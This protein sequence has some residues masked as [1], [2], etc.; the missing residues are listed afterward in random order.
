MQNRKIRK[1]KRIGALVRPS[2]GGG[3][4][5]TED[6]ARGAVVAAVRR[7]AGSDAGGGL[8]GN[9]S[10][11]WHR[12]GPR[13][14]GMLI[15]PAATPPERIGGDDIVWMSLTADPAPGTRP[16]SEWR[17]HRDLY[18]ARPGDGAVVHTHSPYATAL[19]CLPQIQ[20]D[21]LP[22]SH[23][24]IA[25]A[26]GVSL[27]CA[28]YLPYGTQDLSDATIAAIDGRLACL[29]AHHGVVATG[30]T[31]DG[32]LE[33]AFEV[34]RLARIHAIALSA[35]TPAILSPAQLEGLVTRFAAEGRTAARPPGE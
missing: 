7:M 17:M 33:L 6:D 34:E 21:G 29:L 24:M 25:V 32:G 11:R 10:L 5:A 30:A 27:R 31:L 16:S 14:A 18:C 23:Y 8:A 2:P 19:A 12:G 1:R 13:G 35:G 3:G 4:F 22:A 15:T 26:G 9:I 20:R 28:P